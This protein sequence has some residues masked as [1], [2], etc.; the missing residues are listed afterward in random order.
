M[1]NSNEGTTE[2]AEKMQ[3]SFSFF[4][5]FQSFNG[6]ILFPPEKRLGEGCEVRTAV[7]F[8]AKLCQAEPNLYQ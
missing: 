8:V 1:H 4:L 5:I 7:L 6:V 3:R 2:T